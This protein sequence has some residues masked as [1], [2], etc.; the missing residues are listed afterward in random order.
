M[1]T[2]ILKGFVKILAGIVLAGAIPAGLGTSYHFKTIY[3]NQMNDMIDQ[4]KQTQEFK[5]TYNKELQSLEEKHSEETTEIG[6]EDYIANKEYI[7]SDEFA[8]DYMAENNPE[9]HKEYL[10]TENA[11]RKA[12]NAE[13][14]LAIFTGIEAGVIL[15]E[16]ITN[17]VFFWDEGSLKF[18]GFDYPIY[19]GAMDIYDEL[20]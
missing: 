4:V 14:A 10:K 13:V 5:D 3:K 20:S 16:G 6:N 7:N 12:N 9:E 1:F 15:G 19:S 17:M 2:N 8:I 11:Y 18:S